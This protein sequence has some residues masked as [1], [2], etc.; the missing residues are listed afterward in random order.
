MFHSSRDRFILKNAEWSEKYILKPIDLENMIKKPLRYIVR[1][2]HYGSL[3]LDFPI[4]IRFIGGRDGDAEIE[5]YCF[6]YG[7]QDFIKP[8]FSSLIIMRNYIDVYENLPYAV[9][10]IMDLAMYFGAH[11]EYVPKWGS[12]CEVCLL[13]GECKKQPTCRCNQ[14]LPW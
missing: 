12:L 1:D 6:R 4:M 14:F 2:F 13:E 9:E 3:I 10:L 8:Y 5:V 7:D 11:R